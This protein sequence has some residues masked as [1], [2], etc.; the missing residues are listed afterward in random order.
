MTAEQ[1]KAW[2]FLQQQK[3]G[4]SPSP[5]FHEDPLDPKSATQNTKS[6]ASEAAQETQPKGRGEE[7][8]SQPP[9]EEQ[10]SQ[11][12]GPEQ[13]EASEASEASTSRAHFSTGEPFVTKHG[14]IIHRRDP[15]HDPETSWKDFVDRNLRFIDQV[16]KRQV[17]LYSRHSSI[18]TYSYGSVTHKAQPWPEALTAIA[19]AFNI[20]E[21]HDHCLVQKF[22]KSAAINYHADD[23]AL[24]LPG[25]QIT[26]INLGHAELRTRRNSDGEVLFQA[27]FGACSYIMPPGFQ[28]NFK[29]SVTSLED[30]RISITFRTSVHHKTEDTLPWKAWVPILNAAGS[31]DLGQFLDVQDR[32]DE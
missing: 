29:H 26:T 7:K 15:D 21:E 25:S 8:I 24:I 9:V 32:Q 17:T 16:G 6:A 22:K 11:S 1:L 27:L 19:Q 28:S 12:G 20:P 31:L 13:G 3:Q 10:R 30:G 23:E 4:S 18:K 2:D 14:V 5:E